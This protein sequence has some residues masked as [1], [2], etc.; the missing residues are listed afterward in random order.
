[1]GDSLSIR[2]DHIVLVVAQMDITRLETPEDI[3][4]QLNV[5]LRSS[6]M[7]NNLG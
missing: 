3:L 5:F 4:H 6:V 2:R 1:M 7:Y